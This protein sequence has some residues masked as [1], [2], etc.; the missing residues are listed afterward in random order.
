MNHPSAAMAVERD[1]AFAD[2]A[3][4]ALLDRRG[5]LEVGPDQ[6][7][8]LRRS[9]RSAGEF[10]FGWPRLAESTIPLFQDE[11]RLPLV[12]PEIAAYAAA[13]AEHV[14]PV[15]LL[16]GFGTRFSALALL[17]DDGHHPGVRLSVGVPDPRRLG[18]GPAVPAGART[19][20]GL[21][22]SLARVAVVVLTRRRGAAHRPA[23]T[24]AGTRPAGGSCGRTG[25]RRGAACSVTCSPSA[26]SRSCAS[27]IV[28]VASRHFMRAA[29]RRRTSASSRQLRRRS[30]ARCRL[31]FRFVVLMPTAPQI[32][33]LS[34]STNSRIMK[35]RACCPGRWSR[36][37]SNT[38][39]NWS[40]RS[41]AC[42][43]PQVAGAASSVQCPSG[44][45][46][47]SGWGSG[48]AESSAGQSRN[49]DRARSWSAIL[50]R[51]I[52]NTQLRYAARPSN[53]PEPRSAPMNASCT[54]SSAR[55]RVGE[56][57]RGETQHATPQVVDELRV[58][59]RVR[60]P[61]GS[62]GRDGI[63]IVLARHSRRRVRSGR[64]PG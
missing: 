16:I 37:A 29:L 11:Y 1:P 20:Q 45:K 48:S 6:D 40:S 8:G 33:R 46:K 25:T 36:Q 17:R 24:R 15:L 63:R 60:G 23:S 56:L 14:F 21:R 32:S 22:R 7:R 39:Q 3:A 13:T 26:S 62:V 19:R 18:D 59:Q 61:G 9:T 52:A 42:G 30:R 53:E 57:Q 58:A 12:P 35:T 4:R 38:R 49:A 28:R 2:R 55:L 41:A 27:D 47:P 34:S 50:W 10:E 44:S 54:A 64:S 43:S 31:T 51:R 5:V